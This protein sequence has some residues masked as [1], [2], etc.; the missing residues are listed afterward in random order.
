MT[1]LKYAIITQQ[2]KD[3]LQKLQQPEI[4][5]NEELSTDLMKQYMQLKNIERQMAQILGER[6]LSIR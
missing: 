1:D 3:I 2:M 5:K 6:V 4:T